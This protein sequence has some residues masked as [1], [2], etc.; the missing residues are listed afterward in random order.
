MAPRGVSNIS[1]LSSL[2]FIGHILRSNGLDKRLL[3]G[4]VM[5]N[6]GRGRPKTRLSDNVKEIS[7]LTMVEAERMAQDH[8][9]WRRL[10]KRATAVQT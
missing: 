10:V 6:R 4:M 3:T 7:G 9:H 8:D 1:T 2:T 5:Q